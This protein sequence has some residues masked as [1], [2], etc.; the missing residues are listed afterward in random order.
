MSVEQDD[1]LLALFLEESREQLDGIEGDLLSIEACGEAIDDDLVNKVFRAAHSVKGGAGF[2]ALDKVR[3]LAHAM[4]NILGLVR[5]RELAP[6]SPVIGTLLQA[7]DDLVEMINNVESHDE[8]DVSN[9]MHALEQLFIGALPAHKQAHIDARLEVRTADGRVLF[10]PTQVELDTARG[11]DRGGPEL[12][13]LHYDLIDDVQRRGKTPLHLLGELTELTVLIEARIDV[14]TIGTL[15]KYSASTRI[16]FLALLAS[17][18]E[19]LMLAELLDLAPERVQQ[20]V[21]QDGFGRLVSADARPSTPSSPISLPTVPTEQLAS[22]PAPTVAPPVDLHSGGGLREAKSPPASGRPATPSASVTR[23]KPSGS[24]ASGGSDPALDRS[25]RVKLEL[26]DKLMTLA[27]ELV[28][29]RNQLVQS[30]EGDG[31]KV[32]DAT[33]RIDLV[34]TE[35]QDAIMSTRMQSI[36]IVFH[37]FRRVVRELSNELGK[38][39]DLTLE[40]EDVEIDRTIIEAIGDPLTHLVRNAL[41]HGLES[42]QE[43]SRQN[44]DA[45]GSLRLSAFHKA[46]NVIIEI[47]DDGRGI[48]PER[49]RS[50]ALARGL[51]T[52]DQLAAMTDQ[53]LIRLVLKPGFSTAEQVTDLSGRGVGMDVVVSNLAELGGVIDI[54]STVGRGTRVTLKLPLTLA[55][56]PALL[57]TEE[58]QTFAIPQASLVELHRIPARDLSAKVKRIGG[59]S[60]MLLRG[61]LLP[62]V[63]LR[64]LLAIDHRTYADADGRAPDRRDRFERRD[65]GLDLDGQALTLGAERR[66]PHERRTHHGAALNVA[67]VA[68]GEFH[69][70]LVLESFQDSSEIVVKPLG[71]H[72]R[73]CT[74]YAGATILG[75]G[76]P[77]LILDVLGLSHHVRTGALEHIVADAQAAGAN[78]GQDRMTLLLVQS[79]PQESLAIP[80][81][82]VERIERIRRAEIKVLAGKS[83][84][85][86]RGKSLLLL[87][88]DSVANVS[89][90]AP[91]DR[92]YV[93][94]FRAGGR[95][96]GLVVSRLV[97]IIDSTGDLDEHTHRQPGIF[98]SL[99]LEEELVLLLDV[100]GIAGTT[101]PVAVPAAH[102]HVPA[103]SQPASPMEPSAPRIPT[104][105]IVD[106]SKFFLSKIVNFVQEMG[107]H[108]LTADNGARGL[109]L[110]AANIDT[111]DMVLTD[112]EMPELDGFGMSERIRSN[113]SYDALP[114]I[115]ITSVMGEEAQERGR[116][117]G[118]DDYLVK[119]DR[120]MILDRVNHY[121]SHGR[122]G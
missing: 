17:S 120:E 41:D 39:V 89:P 90:L 84:I 85:N 56:I 34:T 57:V 19:P 48:D 79:G 49:V 32:E 33:Q 26:L 24:K 71:R 43:R 88:V 115:A 45:T 96:V 22:L 116:R 83:T 99:L 31:S 5:S 51:H 72:L 44:K 3:E 94:V 97:D 35:L 122:A 20:V 55:I 60:V 28:L 114:I 58:Q 78:A 117:I 101:A 82:L 4:E 107:Y 92:L 102:P 87:Q 23:G 77:A 21:I 38:R 121:L 37:K 53:S 66:S 29:T 64:H 1:E 42:P 74:A 25:I 91:V 110:L 59:S 27:G 113:S 108:T 98:G 50:K 105:L 70:G 10:E 2:F 13:V 80:L 111:I 7:A 11:A 103:T 65:G 75:D 73:D 69:F 62:L 6:S 93:I 95:E 109:E 54:R 16:P 9:S 63:R 112:I 14:A 47:E 40:G 15:E 61:A 52:A 119:L 104:L 46:G 118:I 81:G 18:M 100:Q 30:V 67:I 76:R 106:D 12:Y 86:Y 8:L 36:G 68:A